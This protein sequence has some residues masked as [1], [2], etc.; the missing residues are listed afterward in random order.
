MENL[1]PE[2][3]HLEDC[4]DLSVSSPMT[5]ATVSPAL[6]QALRQCGCN[7][8]A[9]LTPVALQAAR[10]QGVLER[11]RAFFRPKARG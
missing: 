8:A 9:T 3:L 7:A 11:F 5:H 10:E 6:K 1:M 2:P 4:I